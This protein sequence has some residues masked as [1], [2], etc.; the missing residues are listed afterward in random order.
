MKFDNLLTLDIKNLALGGHQQ[1]LMGT[2][3]LTGVKK[4]GVLML[5]GRKAALRQIV[6]TSK[7][8]LKK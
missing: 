1:N 4:Q 5:S 3:R 2:V 6:K 8:K 7:R